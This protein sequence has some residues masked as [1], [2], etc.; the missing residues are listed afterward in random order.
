MPQNN[1]SLA[2]FSTS[3]EGLDLNLVAGL[4]PPTIFSPRL[5][6]QR[7][8]WD[9]A[10]NSLFIT[11]LVSFAGMNVA[12]YFLTRE[13]MAYPDAGETNPLLRP[14]VKNAVSFALFKAAYIALNT[15]GLNSLHQTDKPMA[16]ALSL[17]TNL[18]ATLA[19]THNLSQL[20]KVKNH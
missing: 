7:S 18:L 13:A 20:N 10:E 5:S 6:V 14:I 3:L 16:W 8:F 19:V 4:N 11:S 12:D 15:L 1:L 2:S 9:T 17:A